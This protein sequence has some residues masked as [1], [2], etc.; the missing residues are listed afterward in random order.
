[1]PWRRIVI[2]VRPLLMPIVVGQSPIIL[3]R[4]AI[5]SFIAFP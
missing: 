2:A 1:M 4:V 5:V 3:V